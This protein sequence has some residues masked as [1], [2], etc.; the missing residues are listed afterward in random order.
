MGRFDVTLLDNDGLFQ[1]LVID[2]AP[3]EAMVAGDLDVGSFAEIPL[4]THFST[5]TQDGNGRGLWSVTL[6]LSVFGE[7]ATVFDN[8]VKPIYSGVYAWAD[9][10]KGIVPGIGAVEDIEQ[11]I[12]AFA[13]VGGE[14]QMENKSVIQYTG[15][16]QLAVRNH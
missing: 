1:A 6:T 10:T 12:S 2:I 13:R 8:I 11:E 3:E 9:P 5:A 16:W 7:P 14:A 15:S 4:V